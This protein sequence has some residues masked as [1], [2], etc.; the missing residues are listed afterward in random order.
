MLAVFSAADAQIIVAVIAAVTTMFG[1]LRREI[2]HIGRSV[3]GVG[4]EEPPLIQQVRDLRAHQR[5]QVEAVKELARV[6]GV[7]IPPPPSEQDAA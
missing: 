7:K 2:K 1:L 3:N 4:P 6:L 5:W